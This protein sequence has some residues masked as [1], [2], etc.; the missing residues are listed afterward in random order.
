MKMMQKHIGQLGWGVMLAAVIALSANQLG[1][2]PMI[3]QA[4]LSALTLAI[5]IGMVIGNTVFHRFAPSCAAGIDFSKTRLLRLGIVLYGFRI[6]Y[7]Q[8]A[9]IGWRGI[10]IDIL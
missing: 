6:T 10:V 9:A 8:I 2:Y 4:G 7:Q 1:A 3:A 5:V